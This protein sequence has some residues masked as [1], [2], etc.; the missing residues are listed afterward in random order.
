MRS[1]D[2]NAILVNRWRQK[3]LFILAIQAMHA[4]EPEPEIVPA[5]LREVIRFMVVQIHTAGSNPVQQRFPQMSTRTVDQSDIGKTFA[6]QRISQ[7]GDQFEPACAA[8]D[9]NN[10]MRAGVAGVR[11]YFHS[12][13][14]QG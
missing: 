1:D 11:F 14:P 5:R 12:G 4:P 2:L 3:D 13:F 8:A 6:R 7:T 10:A 9:N